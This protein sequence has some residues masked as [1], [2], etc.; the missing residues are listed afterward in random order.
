MT[1]R[2]GFS[3][4]SEWIHNPN[5]IDLPSFLQ[6][7]REKYSASRL[8]GRLQNQSI[9]ERNLVKAMEIDCTENIG[10]PWSSDVELG[11]KLDF[12]PRSSGI[13]AKFP[14]YRDKIL[15]Q[16]LGR[17]HT[18]ARM[19]VFSDKFDCSLLLRWRRLVIGINED[20]R[21]EE[22]TSGHESRFG[23]SAIRANRL[24]PTDA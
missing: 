14:R 9:P 18:C 10:Y 4:L 23:R 22:T 3:V 12:P 1:K 15:L 2:T 24:G 13:N 20:I 7:F 19:A 16:H 17:Q 21:I 6:V 11:E 8:A 5:A